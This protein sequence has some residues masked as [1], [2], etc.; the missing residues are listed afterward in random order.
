MN[1]LDI[2]ILICL[3]PAIIQGIIKGFISQAISI[4]SL[5]LGVWASARFAGFVCKWLAQYITCSEQVLNI[6]AF[7]L[8]FIIVII[9][10]VLLGKLLEKV[11]KLVMLGWLNRVLGALFATL[12]WLLVMGLISIAFNEINQTLGLVKPE[13]IAGSHLYSFITSFANLVFPYF[14]SIMTA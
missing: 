6:A 13:V 1:I 2:I 4:I 5:I 3:I 11:I 10:L 7:A 12:N 9:L 14:K 8:I